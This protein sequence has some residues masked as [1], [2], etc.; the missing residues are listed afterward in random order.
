M[1]TQLLVMTA[2]FLLN[3]LVFAGVVEHTYFFNADD[4]KMSKTGDSYDLISLKNTLNTAKAGEPSLPYHSVSLLLPPGEKAESIELITY[5]KVLLK[6]DFNIYPQ[7]HSQPFSIGKSGEFVKSTELYNTN[8]IY[9]S[10]KNGHL[11]TEYMNGY[12]FALSTFTPTEYNPVTGELAIYQKITIKITT[13]VNQE[14]LK[15][16]MNSRIS[17]DIQNSIRKLDQNNGIGL[18][19]YEER[20][21]KDINEYQYLIITTATYDRNFNPLIDFYLPR[22]LKTQVVTT[23]FIYANSTG[24]DNPEKIRNYIIQEYQNNGIEFVLLAGDVELVPARGF[25]C[26]V[27]SSSVYTDDNIPA[28]LY[29]SSLDG[30]WNTNNDG[31]WG[32]IGED[33]LLPEISVA[34]FSFSTS[35]ELTNMLNKTMKYQSEPVLGELRDPLFVG[36][37]LYDDPISWGGDYLDLLIGYHEDNGYTTS[38]VPAEHDITKMYDRDAAWNETQ[39]KAEINNGHSFIHHD[40]HSNYTY[41]MRMDNNDVTDATFYNVNGTTHNYTLVYTSGCMCG[42]FDYDDC[43][44]EKFV[45]IENLAVSFIGNS[46]Y[47]WFNEGQTEGPSLHIHREFMDA[48]YGD[49]TARIGTAHKESKIDTAPWVTAPGQWEEGALRWCFYDCNVLG[50]PALNIWTDEPENLSV[51]YSDSITIG[52]TEYQIIVKDSIDQPLSKLNCVLIQDGVIYGS[53]DTDESGYVSISIDPSIQV[54]AA[55]LNISG[56]NTLLNTY[57]IS[58]VNNEGKCI[59]IDSY[60]VEANGDGLIEYGETVNVSVTLKNVGLQDATDLL[61]NLAELDDFIELTDQFQDVGS[62]VAGDTLRIDDAFTFTVSNFVPDIHEITLNS[63]ISDL[64]EQWE[65]SMDFVANSPVLEIT[66]VEI[67]DGGDNILDPGETANLVV[68]FKNKGHAQIANLNGLLSSGDPNIVVNS[69]VDTLSI[70]AT[71]ETKTMIYN[72]SASADAGNGFYYELSMEI[73]ADKEFTFS[74]SF[75]VQT[76]FQVEYFESADFSSFNWFFAGDSDWIIDSANYYEGSYSARSGEIDHDQTSSLVLTDS[77]ITSGEISFYVKTSTEYSWDPFIFYIDDVEID[78]W[79]TGILDWNFNSYPVGSG[80]HTF[81]WSYEKDYMESGGEDCVWLDNI[82]FPGIKNTT[83]IQIGNYN[84][85]TS[86]MLHQNYPNPFNPLT[87]ISYSISM[88]SFVNLSV[89]NVKGEKVTT[90][91]DDFCKKGNYS[92]K[93]SGNHLESGMYFYRMDI[94]GNQTDVRR[95]LLIK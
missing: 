5:D 47:G 54:G 45:S 90:L 20:E 4:I 69:A 80:E 63:I 15:A 77:V 37:Y 1:K 30:N 55:E 59:V 27:Q 81:K 13:S 66:Q 88:N 48:L 91:V 40:G 38:G 9:P 34:R 58:V 64:T 44:A 43:F 22:G 73:T 70:L 86:S 79:D 28:D 83:G 23:D 8:A 32:E 76:G 25:F 53:A 75:D 7:Q 16:L 11:S 92:I 12:S 41:N 31:L 26:S 52:E 72:I 36:E 57:A 29:Y 19:Q 6:G 50:D 3:F 61:M 51:N 62:I 87:V 94:D 95:M 35:L 46:R 10:E 82:V 42:G 17:E 85:P 74:D 21:T 84:L 78:R 60:R 2:I 18:G 71:D 39:L 65:R 33:D 89:Y 93:F 49:R 67:Q 68:S 56:Y 14:S 24:V